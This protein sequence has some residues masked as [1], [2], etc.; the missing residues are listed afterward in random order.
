MRRPARWHCQHMHSRQQ[1]RQMKRPLQWSAVQTG[2]TDNMRR[3]AED[4]QEAFLSGNPA[5]LGGKGEGMLQVN[6]L[7]C[8][9]LEDLAA[10]QAG[11]KRLASASHNAVVIKLTCLF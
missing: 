2:V 5:T 6:W 7:T 10:S 3:L 4:T 8:C 1:P 11:L 9:L